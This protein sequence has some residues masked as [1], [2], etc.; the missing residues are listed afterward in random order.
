MEVQTMEP[1]ATFAANISEEPNATFAANISEEEDEQKIVYRFELKNGKPTKLGD[2]TFGAVLKVFAPNGTAYAAK[3]FY[4]SKDQTVKARCG[5][6]MHAK[7]DLTRHLRDH[8]LEELNVNLVLAEAWTQSFQSS[9]AYKALK[10][11]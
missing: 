6:E 3:L 10:P 2:G 5:Q 1:N 7:F 4:E 9:D 8:K 11:Y